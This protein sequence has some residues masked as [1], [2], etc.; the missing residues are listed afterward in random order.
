MT[1]KEKYI[2]LN[3]EG[4]YRHMLVYWNEIRVEKAYTTADKMI[5]LYKHLL[6]THTELM[7]DLKVKR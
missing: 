3:K 5:A 4:Y 7:N 1:K 2:L 6:M